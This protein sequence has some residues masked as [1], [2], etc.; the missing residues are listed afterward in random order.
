MPSRIVSKK[1]PF[2]R[3]LAVLIALVGAIAV[4]DGA[5]GT[6]KAFAYGSADQ[7][8]AQITF[9]ANCDNP[10]VSLC[11]TFGVGGFWAWVEID[12]GGTA[13]FTAAGCSHTVGGIGGPGGAGAGGFHGETGWVTFTGTVAQVEAAFPSP[14]GQPPLFVMPYP[15]DS[16]TNTYYVLPELGFAVPTAVGHYSIKPAAGAQVQVQVAP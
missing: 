2:M 4:V 15:T 6:G 13:D 10:S 9:S 8:L 14:P 3:K 16:A 5:L 7:P 11:Q 12:T 1:E